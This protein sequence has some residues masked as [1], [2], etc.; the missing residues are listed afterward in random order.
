MNMPGMATKC[1]L[2]AM[3]AS[4]PARLTVS[5]RTLASHGAPDAASPD[6]WGVAF[7]QGDHVVLHREAAP[8]GDSA[9]VRELEA[10]GPSTPLALSHIRRATQGAVTLANTQPF[11]RELAGRTHVFAHNGNLPGVLERTP[12]PASRYHPVGQTD[13]E[14]VF[15]DLMER[16]GA[17]WNG[18]F[19]PP[20]QDRLSVLA[21]F[22]AELRP[23]GPA[24]FLYADGDALFAHGHRRIQRESGRIEPPGLWLLQ[25]H[26][27]PG[28]PFPDCPAIAVRGAGPQTVMLVASVPLTTQTWRPLAEGELVAIRGGEV[29]STTLPVVS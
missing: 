14:R 11:V 27:K 12:L 10:G 22:A 25:R 23:L 13:S 1:E 4:Q 24:N 9:L 2:L 7:Y 20:L 17:L 8:A 19:V 15:C 18:A 16:L 26:C 28:D 29:V 3:S 5:L 6:G 21:A